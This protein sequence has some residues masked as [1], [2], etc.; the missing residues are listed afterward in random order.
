MGR[1]PSKALVT[2]KHFD[3][4]LLLAEVWKP[5]KL[6]SELLTYYAPEV[7]RR[8]HVTPAD[9]YAFDLAATARWSEL[10]RDR[11]RHVADEAGVYSGIKPS[12]RAPSTSPAAAGTV[13]EQGDQ[14]SI[15]GNEIPPWDPRFARL[16]RKDGVK[17]SV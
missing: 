1:L 4:L 7:V 3:D 16:R 10:Q 13:R 15:R 11:E 5:G 17:D 8:W 14:L 2:S 12:L 6:P 9:W